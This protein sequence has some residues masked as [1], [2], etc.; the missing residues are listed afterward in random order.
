MPELAEEPLS[1]EA[2]LILSVPE[3]LGKAVNHYASLLLDALDGPAADPR[4]P[5]VRSVE[6]AK[7]SSV[8]GN[9][10]QRDE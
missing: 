7:F 10:R 9:Q 4:C 8:Y 6:A 5:G 2:E 3:A 1:A